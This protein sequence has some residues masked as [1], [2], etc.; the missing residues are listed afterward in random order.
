M[1]SFTL[2]PYKALKYVCYFTV[3]ERINKPLLIYNVYITYL[4]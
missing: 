1:H 4:S 2:I 3:Y